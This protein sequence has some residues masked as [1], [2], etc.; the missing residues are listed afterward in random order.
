M[1]TMVRI[2]IP[3]ADGNRAIMDGTL[4]KVME[5]A[6]A[7]LKP[8]AAYFTAEKGQRTAYLFLDMTDS[9]DLPAVAERFWFGWNASVELVPVMYADE[10]RRGLPRAMASISAG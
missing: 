1:R 9:A 7:E 8:E 6:M 3:A 2:A 10:L 5:K 4:G